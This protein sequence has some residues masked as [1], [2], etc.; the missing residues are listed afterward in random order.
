MTSKNAI[1]LLVASLIHLS[2][3]AQ[4]CNGTFTGRMLDETNRPIV[5]AAILIS[6]PEKGMVTDATGKFRFNK[7]CPGDYS[8]TVQFIGYEK[9]EF[10]IALDTMVNQVIHLKEAV[11]ELREVVIQDEVLNTE[12]AHNVSKLTEKQLAESA[13]KSLGE[14]LKEIPG[15]NSIQTGPGIFKPVIHG[16]HS[17]RVLI[18]NNGLRQEG[19]QWGAEHAP[20]IDPFVA[21]N[22][23]VIKDASSI[24]YGTDAL[25]GVIVINPPM[26]PEKAGLSGSVNSIIQSNGRSGTISGLLEGGVKNH[27][28]WGWRVQGTAKRAGDFHTPDYSLTNTGL[29]ELNFSTSTGYHK[30]N[31]GIE[32]FFSHFQT[33]LG[34]LK[35][36][37]TGNAEDLATA[38][39]REVPQH[40]SSFSYDIGEPRQE[41]SHNLFKLNGHVKLKRSDLRLQYGLQNNHRKEFDLRI[42]NL[43]Q[44]P[45]LNLQLTTHTLEVE[46][47]TTR[48]EKS[49]LCIGVTG[50]SQINS[51]VFGTRRI[52]F[53]PNFTN[54]SGGLFAITKLYIKR[55]TVDL[56][57]RYDYR[58]Y[59][60][61]GYDNSNTLFR[62]KSE[63]HNPSATAGATIKLKKDQT[64]ILN[65]SS[66]W[67]PPHVAELYS[68]G[69][70]QSA[71]AN[72]YGLLLD[73]IT[74][75]VLDIK[76]ID[77]KTEQ[78]VK[79]V[80]TYQREWKNF[81][82]EVSPYANYIFNYIYLRP[83]GITTN[84]RGTKPALRY[85][86]TDALFLG[87]DF[88]AM[89]NASKYIKVIPKASLLRASD[90]RN[91]D[92]LIQMPSNRYEVAV[93]YER[94][95][96]YSFRNFFLESKL[97]Y[98][99][100]QRR[101]PRVISPRE[102]KAAAEE[103][104]D[105]LQG[106]STNFDFMAAPDGYTLWT[107]AAGISTRGK[108][109]QYDFR[110]SSE[111]T[112]NVSYRE[113][114][115]RFRYY[116]DDIGRNFIFSVKCI[117]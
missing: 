50:M 34:I 7:L 113:Y 116:A 107:I 106:N 15:V 59:S 64:L 83:D 65:L 25:G 48:S 100:R 22:I 57:A 63:F 31:V 36:T 20:E 54:L 30:E 13:G 105:P 115:N 77:F 109:V 61:S 60:V 66:A 86:Q 110:I 68:L 62:S 44:T 35:G 26:L 87:V 108:K 18:L 43:S 94:P 19:Q 11:R 95:A 5:G 73:K 97:K 28:G 55:W 40:T 98:I 29:R 42:G 92:Y 72:E 10:N 75:E 21:S 56:G 58:Y 14:S 4:E 90:E 102:F 27:D 1:L 96:F 52:P 82:I 69:T 117:F 6:P 104:T 89:W 3:V 74:N 17:Q 78:A 49:S 16:V 8:V 37:A 23:V 81:Q 45:D 99:D 41:V 79:W 51:T 9:V 111:N 76:S 38:M 32:A 47:E 39:E 80:S 103:G 88:S 71:A 114:T 93:R 85:T 91:N 84:L 2:S 53:I 112:L 33:E 70:H 46:M 67:R 24:K 12:H 101:A